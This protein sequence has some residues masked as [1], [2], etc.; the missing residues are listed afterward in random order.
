MVFGGYESHG[1]CPGFVG[2]EEALQQ[3][4]G[5]SHP[6]AL[7]PSAKEIENF[8]MLGDVRRPKTETRYPHQ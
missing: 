7:A 1:V 6:L 4:M 3:I 5:R 2:K 8:E